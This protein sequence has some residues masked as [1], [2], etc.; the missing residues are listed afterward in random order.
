MNTP[1]EVN[2]VTPMTVRVA[3][4]RTLATAVQ[5]A[6]AAVLVLVAGLSAGQDWDDIGL[7]V[8]GAF[9]TPVATCVHRV[10]QALLDDRRYGG[11]I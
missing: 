11:E 6:A 9:L 10:T 1:V 3:V 8:A 5:A 4:R 2:I 7:I